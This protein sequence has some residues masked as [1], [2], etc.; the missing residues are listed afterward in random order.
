MVAR[1]LVDNWILEACAYTLYRGLPPPEEHNTTWAEYRW[2]M[3]SSDNREMIRDHITALQWLLDL[4]LTHD[5]L[6]FDPGWASCPY[7]DTVLRE[8]AELLR[9]VKV[10][11]STRTM[12]T[13]GKDL[14]ERRDYR[15][16]VEDGAEY[17]L[18]LSR[19]LGVTYW[20][21]PQRAE[22]IRGKEFRPTKDALLVLSQELNEELRK[23]LEEAVAPF[24]LD[25]E[26]RLF[27]FSRVILAQCKDASEILART[28]ALREK[29][30]CQAFR[31]WIRDMDAALESGDI[32]TIASG[33]RE[34]R[35]V[36]SWFRSRVLGFPAP[37]SKRWGTRLTIGLSPSISIDASG[38]KQLKPTSLHG[39]FLRT[40]C[41]T[42]KAHGPLYRQAGRLFPSIKEKPEKK[43]YPRD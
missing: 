23:A 43:W 20:P 10:E 36:L 19:V 35:A 9:P 32:K 8:I 13:E 31:R 1:C 3:S 24:S 6:L 27:G 17:Y 29:R 4:I 15:W 38:L 11:P 25:W 37:E 41:K 22:F 34:L 39:T 30:E 33:I 42:L 5:E 14:S 26:P 21:S 18:G 12:L 28:I 7:E 2:T 40:Y 16:I